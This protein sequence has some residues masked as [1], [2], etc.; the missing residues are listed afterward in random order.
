MK[1]LF[2]FVSLLAVL[3][4]G[5]LVA[6]QFIDWQKYKPLIKTEVQK[7]TGLNVTINGDISMSVFPLPHVKVE[8]LEVEAPLK[9]KF[10]KL[11]T[12]E[13]AEVSVELLPLL[14][15]K[16]NVKRVSLIKPDIT[17]E[18]LEDGTPSWTTSKLSNDADTTESNGTSGAETKQSKDIALSAVNI[19]QGKVHFID[20]QTGKEHIV[21][22]A[23]FDLKADSLSGPFD[24]GGKVTYNG[25]AIDFD[26]ETGSIKNKKSIP[27]K[28]SIETVGTILLFDGAGAIEDGIEAQGKLK[29][30]SDN[31]VKTGKAF[32]VDLPSSYNKKL[33]LS[34]IVTADANNISFDE[35]VL[36]YDALQMSG[37]FTAKNV[38]EQNPLIVSGAL[39]SDSI[40]DTS[41]FLSKSTP[42]DKAQTDSDFLK[43]SGQAGKSNTLIPNTLSLPFP[44]TV[45]FNLDLA[46]IQHDKI[47]FKGVTASLNKKNDVI[48][49]SFRINEMPGQGRSN[50]VLKIDYASQSGSKPI[51][52]ADPTVTY[53]LQ[54]N[55]EQL[56]A[57]LN[58]VAPASNT[59]NITDMY[60]STSFDVNGSIAG[61]A[62]KINK[63]VVELDDTVIG[64]SGSYAPSKTGGKANAAIDL[65]IGTIDI[66]KLTGNKKLSAG[67]TAPVQA[68]PSKGTKSD[69]LKTLKDFSLPVDLTFDVSAQKAVANNQTF[70]GVRLV[71][72]IIGN[73]LSVSNASINDFVGAALSVKG[74]VANLNAL[75]GIDG[76][77]SLKTSDLGSFAK[78]INLDLSNLPSGINALDLNV[79]GQGALDALTFAANVKA[80]GGQ[81][82]A[83]GLAK[84]LMGTPSYN[85]LAVRIKHPNGVKAIQVF[86]PEFKGVEGL[87]QAIDVYAK[88]NSNGKVFDLKEIQAA[89]GKTSVAGNLNIDT[90]SKVMGIKGDI[91]GKV[92]ELDSLLGAEKSSGGY[93]SSSTSGGSSKSSSGGKWTDSPIDLG[94]MNTM[95]VDVGLSADRL[96]YGKWNFQ[97]PNTR[98]KIANGQ[99]D[100]NSL[101]AGVFGG[102]ATLTSKVTAEPVTLSLSTKMDNI[103]LESLASA[104]SGSSRLKAAGNVSFDTSVNGAGKS[105]RAL[106]S[107]L[108]GTA[109]LDG[110]DVVLKGFDLAKLA[111]GLSVEQKFATS[112]QNFAQGALKS[113]ETRFDTIKGDYKIEQGIVRIQTMQM[114]GPAAVIDSTGQADLP[115]W[116]INV[117]NKVTI[118]GVSGLDPLDIKIK[119]SI[120]NPKTLGTNIVED[121]IKD[122]LKRK[123]GSELPGLLGDDVTNKLQQFGILPKKQEQKA[124]ANDNATPEGSSAQP[125]PVAPVKEEPKKIEK[126]ADA[127]EQLLNSDNAEDA[128]NNLIKGLF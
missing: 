21:T 25:A 3:I 56:A 2:G 121:Y 35:L 37:K 86:S 104:L 116:F 89:I 14:E 16:V 5:A 51:T 60:R 55:I 4:V 85:D 90:S 125:Q 93:S 36:G 115:K 20:H 33:S 29:I 72:S 43:K 100:I 112:L 101:K 118:K 96:T 52:Y 61:S 108:N 18:I 97:N 78:A 122:K 74:K 27:V 38:T 1:F 8:M 11:I 64:L 42:A 17:I 111:Q 26:L 107:S 47:N 57:F 128:V 110:R 6:P 95:N 66:D 19:E 7:A 34:S 24:T 12:V 105:S 113:G 40:I 76:A 49:S 80:L 58:Q 46:G 59:K 69:P 44:L 84:D 88:I 53:S 41:M 67:S 79:E 63:G 15:K 13:Q 87:A 102:T 91:K 106:V 10:D 77:V 109:T 22:E 39:K 127:V 119:G 103:D 65:Q 71:G 45:D 70:N 114:D 62:V 75:K 28:A 23:N 48:N 124:P 9:K 68:T 30:E 92:I 99:L 81:V 54:G 83:S 50:G 117:D 31:L 73:T 98:I 32:S 126:P 82:D 120:D 94:W 123:L